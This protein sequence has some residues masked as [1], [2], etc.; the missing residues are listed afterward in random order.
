LVETDHQVVCLASSLDRLS[1][2]PWRADVEVR[3]CDVL[4]AAQVRSALTGCDVAYYL[5]HSMGDLADFA[6]ADRTAAENFAQAAE[7]NHLA[8]IVYLG[9]IVRDDDLSDHLASRQEV[10]QTLA[11]GSTPVTELRAGVVIG[12]GSVSFEMLRYLTEVL[13][14]MVTPRWVETLTQP[15]AID[16]VLAYLTTALG[17]DS[18]SHIYEIGGPDVVSYCEMMQVYARVAGLPKRLIVPVPLLT[19]RLSSL[20]IG[21]VTPLPVAVARPGGL[22]EE[23]SNGS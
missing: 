7:A 23:R 2:R 18:G 14:V 19:P 11:T 8:R 20:W 6:D 16:D 3:E 12:S 21:L 1:N 17:D 10:G 4:D 9:G 22:P 15:V 5:I 13:P